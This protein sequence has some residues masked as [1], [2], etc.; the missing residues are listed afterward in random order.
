MAFVYELKI[1]KQRIA[2]LIGKKGEIKKEIEETTKVS[3]KVDSK[4]GDVFLEGED[5][6]SLYTARE[7]VKAIG[8]GFNPEIAKRLLKPDYVYDQINI[9]DYAKTKNALQRLKGRVIGSEGKSRKNIESLTGC[10]LMVFGKTISIIGQSAWVP[11]ARHAI[12]MLLQ[13]SP[14]STVYNWLEKKCKE[15]RFKNV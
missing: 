12:G 9:Q 1:P 6:L 8:R 3:I 10:S 2:V 4:E 14:H 15:L 11:I 13:G 5:G 7:V